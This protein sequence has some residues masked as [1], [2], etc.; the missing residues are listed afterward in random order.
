[1]RRR[2]FR[3]R[4]RPRPSLELQTGSLPPGAR[5]GIRIPEVSIMSTSGGA[6][7]FF[8]LFW[9]ALAAICRVALRLRRRTNADVRSSRVACANALTG[10]YLPVVLGGAHWHGRRS[11]QN[12]V[13]L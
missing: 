11:L 8:S 3:S 7:V 10:V 13:V 12:V 4:G 1:M 6:T 2:Q 9:F 5:G